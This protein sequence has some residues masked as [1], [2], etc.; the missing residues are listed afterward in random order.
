MA[1]LPSFLMLNKSPGVLVNAASLHTIPNSMRGFHLFTPRPA[2][3]F[4]EA[5]GKVPRDNPGQTRSSPPGA[6]LSEQ[7]TPASPRGVSPKIMLPILWTKPRAQREQE[8][9][10]DTSSQWGSQ[11]RSPGTC[12][13]RACGQLRGPSLHKSLGSALGTG[14]RTNYPQPPARGPSVLLG[15]ECLLVKVKGILRS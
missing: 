12:E 15:K 13:S 9:P 6:G 2:P 5:N 14:L 3:A 7:S 10:K 8:Q 11:D 1:G 4:P